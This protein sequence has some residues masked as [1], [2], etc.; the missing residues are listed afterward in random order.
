MRV[1]VFEHG[2]WT[3]ACRQRGHDIVPLPAATHPSGNAYASDMGSRLAIGQS[4]A[5]LLREQGADFLLDNSGTGL[6]FL[7]GLN[8]SPSDIALLHE[9]TG[10]VLCSHFIDPMVTALQGIGWQTAWQCLQSTQWVKAIWDRAQAYE[11][12]RFGVP[13]VLHIPMAAPVRHYD[14]TPIDPA[15]QRRVVSFIGGQNTTFFTSNQ[16]V[17]TAALL[18]GVLAGAT[19]PDMPHAFFWDLYH[20]AYGLGQPILESDDAHTRLLKTTNYF[21]AKLFYNASLC[22]RNRDRFVI[23]LTRKLGEHFH[24][25]G[26]GWDTAYGIAPRNPLPTG[27]PYFQHFRD[28]AININLVNGNAE[29]GLNMRH[30]EITAAGGF[31]LCYRQPEL[32]TCFDIGKECVMFTSEADLLEKI[33]YY[34]QHPDERVAIAAAGQRRTLNNHLYSH[35]LD[36]LL[37]ALAPGEPHIKFSLTRWTDDCK[38]LLPEA[39]IV[40]DI[41]A[42]VGYMAKGLRKLYP[43]AEIHSFEPVPEVFEQL[44]KTCVDISAHPVQKAVA[45]RDGTMTMN[46]TAS[47]ECHSLLG[48]QEG[49]PCAQWTRIVGEQ[50]VDVCTLDHWC[51]ENN[52]DPARIDLVKLDIQGAELKALHGARRVLKSAKVVYTEVSFVPLYK[53]SPLLS[54]I[55]GFLANCG[56]RRHAIY[57]S[58]QPQNWGDALYVKT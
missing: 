32:A 21:N 16:A 27:T 1:G 26:H 56:F 12:Q 23:F 17:G 19:H 9:S 45:D 29:G 24:L 15:K 25:H 7:P 14:T 34:L 41:G 38:S 3:D 46:L 4:V 6:G 55:D 11:L 30:F 48:F 20:D 18:P 37:S 35:R 2:W 43:Q 28:T 54:D 33:D 53:E 8:D 5:R 36:T 52:I 58:D 42:N 50:Q 47:S 49:N 51:E 22:M 40:L 13:N 57:P 31:M 39:D 10:H 44:Q